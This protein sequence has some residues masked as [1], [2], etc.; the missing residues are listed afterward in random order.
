MSRKTCNAKPLI[1][2]KLENLLKTLFT[3][4]AFLVLVLASCSDDI[5]TR[6]GNGNGCRDD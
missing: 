3:V 1:I 5:S 2:K 6:Y 4:L